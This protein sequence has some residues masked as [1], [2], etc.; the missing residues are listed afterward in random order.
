MPE[1]K[2]PPLK[3]GGDVV[4]A[5]AGGAFAGTVPGK[6][7]PAKLE[8]CGGGDVVDVGKPKDDV[9]DCTGGG[10]RVVDGPDEKLSPLNAS[11]RPPK[12]SCLGAECWPML[13]KDAWRSCV[14]C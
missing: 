1:K 12:A 11:A 3:G 13:L 10:D 6:L 7:R 5:A 9:G 4:C 2:L 14:G 8:D